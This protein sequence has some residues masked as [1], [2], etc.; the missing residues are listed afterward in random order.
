MKPGALNILLMQ[1]GVIQQRRP[2]PG[3]VAEQFTDAELY[4]LVVAQAITDGTVQTKADFDAMVRTL[5][6]V[7][8]ADELIAFRKLRPGCKAWR[9]GKRMVCDCGTAWLADNP[10]PPDCKPDLDHSI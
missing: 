2:V 8:G 4:R 3:E 9:H 6:T 10:S 5:G 1:R 7:A